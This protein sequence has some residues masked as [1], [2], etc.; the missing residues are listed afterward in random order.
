[1]NYVLE[2]LGSVPVKEKIFSY[3]QHPDRLKRPSTLLSNL[4]R[5]LFLQ[6]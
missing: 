5:G 3:P 4:Y 1:M 2:G 6:V